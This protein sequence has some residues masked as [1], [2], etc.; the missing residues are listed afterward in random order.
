MLAV[1]AMG[2]T[3]LQVLTGRPSV[4]WFDQ[5]K[6]VLLLDHCE[7]GSEDV[8]AII[9]TNADWASHVAASL[10]ELG[11]QCTELGHRKVKAADLRPTV[12]Q[13]IE[14]LCE[15]MTLS[16]LS[17]PPPCQKECV[18]CLE[19]PRGR[20]RF[21]PCPCLHASVAVAMGLNVLLCQVSTLYAVVDVLR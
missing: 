20:H 4:Q 6:K 9:D 13:C 17:A 8:T 1:Y 3:L 5:G 2:L 11:L 15:F 7:E 12:A 10:L 19:E 14:Q 18:V 21:M 16:P